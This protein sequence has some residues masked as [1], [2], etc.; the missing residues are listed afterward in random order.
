MV[1][2]VYYYYYFIVVV[3]VVHHYEK[4]NKTDCCNYQRKQMLSHIVLSRLT[5]YVDEIIGDH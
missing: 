4:E 2:T 1:S 5:P 3:V